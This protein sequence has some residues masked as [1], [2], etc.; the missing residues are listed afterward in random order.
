MEQKLRRQKLK[1]L[2]KKRIKLEARYGTLK[3]ALK[4]HLDDADVAEYIKQRN[5]YVE[6]NL[7]LVEWILQSLRIDYSVNSSLREEL[8]SEL[9]IILI[10]AIDSF[11]FSKGSALSSYVYWKMR[12]KIKEITTHFENERSLSDETYNSEDADADP[13]EEK[14]VAVELKDAAECEWLEKAKKEVIS[15]LGSPSEYQKLVAQLELS[16]EDKQ[17]KI[18]AE[19]RNLLSE[20]N[21]KRRSFKI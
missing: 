16:P 12:N 14:L 2:V 13:P 8:R 7:G 10:E 9:Q 5:K 21:K 1:S 4:S 18:I 6:S 20:K 15:L 19:V 3:E 11:D 17:A